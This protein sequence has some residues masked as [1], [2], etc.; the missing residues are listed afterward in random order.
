MKTIGEHVL[1]EE[2]NSLRSEI[3]ELKKE[4]R[5]LKATYETTLRS[6]ENYKRKEVNVLKSVLLLRHDGLLSLSN[7][8]I[9][10]RYSSCPRHIRTLSSLVVRKA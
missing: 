4:M 5:K 6:R 9:G 10:A 1:K 3:S 8:E 7:D 2:N